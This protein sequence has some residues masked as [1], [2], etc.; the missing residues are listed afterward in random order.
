[1]QQVNIPYKDSTLVTW[2]NEQDGKTWIA[3][4]PLCERLGIQSARQEQKVQDDPRFNC[5]H[6]YAVAEDGKQREMVALQVEQ[7]YGWLY[8]INPNK[9]SPESYQEI[10]DFQKYCT[11]V[12]YE[13]ASGQANSEVV[14]KLYEIIAKLESRVAQ[15]DKRIEAMEAELHYVRPTLNQVITNSSNLLR[16]GHLKS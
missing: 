16:H 2:L 8:T 14:Q 5:T 12:I 7:V 15:Q 10:L 3:L 11:Q 13:A 4:K 1:M 9:V 6:M